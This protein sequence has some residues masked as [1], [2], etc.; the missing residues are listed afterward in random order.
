MAPAANAVTNVT[1][2][3]FRIRFVLSLWG[4]RAWIMIRTSSLVLTGEFHP[5]GCSNHC[6]LAA[7]VTAP[8]NN[9]TKYWRPHSNASASAKNADDTFPNSLPNL[10]KSMYLVVPVSVGTAANNAKPIA[11]CVAERRP[12]R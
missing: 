10:A 7:T 5:R 11:A 4:L 12:R 1:A 3:H 9:S 6:D 2:F 8:F